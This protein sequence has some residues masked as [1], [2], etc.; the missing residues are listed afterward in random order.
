MGEY[1]NEQRAEALALLLSGETQVQ[2]AKKLGVPRTT[3][4]N[5]ARAADLAAHADH[6]DGHGAGIVQM[7]GEVLDLA[8]KRI[9]QQIPKAKIRDVVGVVSVIAEKH[10]LATGNPTAIHGESVVVPEGGSI[11]DVIA[12]I[13][14]RREARTARSG[15]RGREAKSPVAGGDADAAPDARDPEAEMVSGT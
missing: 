14:R 6:N 2:V 7:Y 4:G 3:V 10:A 1:T 15:G 11:D 5:W 8:L 12:E 9:R 13:R